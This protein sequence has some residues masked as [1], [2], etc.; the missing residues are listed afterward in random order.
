LDRVKG[1]LC[2]AGLLAGAAA[3]VFAAPLA[4]ARSQSA[5]PQ[6]SQPAPAAPSPP[7]S[8]PAPAARPAAA[9]TPAASPVAASAVPIGS[10]PTTGKTHTL[11]DALSAAYSNNPTLLAERAKVRSVDENVPQALAGWRPQVLISAAPGYAVGNYSEISGGQAITLRNNRDIFSAQAGV[12]QYLYRGG[13][14]RAQT[15]QAENGVMA[16]RG[17]LIATEQ[18]VFANVVNAFVTV[19]ENQQ[20]LALNI[21]N[22][23]VLA[24][25]LQATNDRFRVGE[26]TRTDVAQ[27]EAALAGATSQRQVAEGNL[28]TARASYR[29]YVGEM[30]ENLVEPQPLH[31]PVSSAVEAANLAA[32]NNPAV[33]A[34]LFDDSSAKDAIDVAFSALL[35]TLSVQAAAIESSNASVSHTTSTGGQITANLSLPLF[36]GGSE[37]AAVRQARQNEQQSRK[38]LDDQRRQAMEQSTSAWETLVAARAS[39]ES[40]RLAIRANSIALEGVEREAIVGSRTTLDV[41]N[42]EQALLT[43]R[44]TL[45]QNLAALINASY[46]LAQA[47]GRLT[48]KD[49]GLKVPLYD[50]TAYYQAVHDR[51]AGTGDY[52][53]D[54]PGR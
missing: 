24:R 1:G 50:E 9:T 15:A 45:V 29:Q 36:Q 12:T 46:T 28:Q 48:A 31:P 25:Q 40:T 17:R 47:V 21:N 7:R 13:K 39:I 32:V 30:P 42:A 52:A 26:I 23:Q 53:T 38:T 18:T 51:W 11:Q 54:Q 16:E 22:E 2:K 33:I 5:T 4:P 41:L 20:L 35:P 49:L 8:R 6:V 34:A 43:S 14:T 37:Y 3:L 10:N 44:V 27:A 19:I